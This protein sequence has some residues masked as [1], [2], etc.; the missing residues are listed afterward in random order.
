MPGEY[1]KEYILLRMVAGC[2]Y[3]DRRR[4]YHNPGRRHGPSLWQSVA[5]KPFISARF[6]L[7]N[8]LRTAVMY[9]AVELLAPSPQPSPPQGRGHQSRHSQEDLTDVLDDGCSR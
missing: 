2:Q 9:S 1:V 7:H 6:P 3:P 8:A 5:K 4:E